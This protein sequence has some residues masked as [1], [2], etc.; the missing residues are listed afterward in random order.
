MHLIIYAILCVFR[1]TK[2]NIEVAGATVMGFAGA[3]YEEHIQP[4][5]G[6]YFDWASN[7]RKSMW[8]MIQTAVEDYMPSRN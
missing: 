3:Y 2:A 1:Q 7:V 6:G 4:V 8:D 5:T